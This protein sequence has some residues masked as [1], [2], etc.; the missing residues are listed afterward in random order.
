M[1]YA[2]EG[3]VGRGAVTYA[4]EGVVGRGATTLPIVFGRF[5]VF[6]FIYVLRN[7]RRKIVNRVSNSVT[8]KYLL[9]NLVMFPLFYVTN[10][11]DFNMSDKHTFI[12]L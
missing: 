2:L 11:R 12:S 5:F 9:Y 3:V 1:T 10:E 4:L 6:N 7:F 8:L